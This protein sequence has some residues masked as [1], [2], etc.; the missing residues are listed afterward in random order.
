MKQQILWYGGGGLLVV[1]AVFGGIAYKQGWYSNDTQPASAAESQSSATVNIPIETIGQS[2]IN[3]PG[4]S[5]PGEVFSAGDVDVQPLREGTIMTWYVRIGQRVRQGQVLAKLAAPQVTPDLAEMLAEQAESLTRAKAEAKATSAFVQKSLDQLYAL[6]SA[7]ETSRSATK[8]T[9]TNVGVSEKSNA[10]LS[11]RQALEEAQNVIDARQR[12]VRKT[13]ERIVA[14]QEPIFTDTLSIRNPSSLKYPQLKLGNGT[15]AEERDHYLSL[16][17]QLKSALKDPNSVPV[18]LAMQ[19]TQAAIDFVNKTSI[20]PA[21]SS[22]V[23]ELEEVR[24]LADDHQRDLIEAINEHKE[25]IADMADKESEYKA[26][27][28]EYK[29]QDTEY[30]L[31]KVGEDKDYAEKSKEINGQIAELE[32]EL[33]LAQAEVAGAQVAY[34]TVAGAIYGGLNIVAPRAGVVSTVLKKN[35]ELVGPG[36]SVA[37]INS[38]KASDLLVRFR[39]PGNTPPPAIGQTL[40]VVRPSSPK[41]GKK[42]ELVGISLSLDENG[43]FIADADFVNPSEIDWPTH[44][45]VRVL[46]E[47][48]Q[49]QEVFVS[50]TSIWWNDQG[51]ASVWLVTEQDR[52][53]MQEL[54]TGRTLGDKIEIIEGLSFGDRIIS[55]PTPELATGMQI[56]QIAQPSAAEEAEAGGDGH[57]HE[58]E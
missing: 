40:T 26:R 2:D 13:I 57:G 24:E 19:Y 22:E 35:G 48:T 52:L 16:L 43:A 49:T 12:E 3:D 53:R 18:D 44:A 46:P 8:S 42:V 15:N 51:R 29:T 50:F 25:A 23:E 1:V 7:F 5:W 14:K 34:N 4:V 28:V 30:E 55:Q 21:I 36:D 17:Q 39:I 11:A 6:R 37:S 58:H 33:E 27:E 41:D 38:G 54:K 9:L 56:Q 32:K 31:T 10:L 47:V 20:F 45:S